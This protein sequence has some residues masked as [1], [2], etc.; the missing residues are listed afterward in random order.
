MCCGDVYY[1][2]FTLDAKCGVTVMFICLNC[3]SNTCILWGPPNTSMQMYCKAAVAVFI[4]NDVVGCCWLCEMC[5]NVLNCVYVYGSISFLP[6]C[7]CNT[8][9][10]FPFQLP[11]GS[12]SLSLLYI[13]LCRK[14]A[15]GMH[16]TRCHNTK[17]SVQYTTIDRTATEREK[18]KEGGRS[19]NNN[20]NHHRSSN[21][22]NV[23]DRSTQISLN[24]TFRVCCEWRSETTARCAIMDPRTR[25]KGT[26]LTILHRNKA[27]KCCMFHVCRSLFVYKNARVS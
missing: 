7:H 4:P 5:V 2:L 18:E 1:L 12:L 21:E 3:T 25:K 17:T 6:F 22:R 27:S 20:Y 26:P 10:I 23:R 8:I 16:T 13:Y 11:L 24:R 19:E 14:D 15:W 9:F